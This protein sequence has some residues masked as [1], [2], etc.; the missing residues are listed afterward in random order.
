MND[1]VPVLSLS[2]VDVY[3]NHHLDHLP[4]PVGLRLPGDALHAEGLHHPLPPR[5]ERAQT[6]TQ[7]QG[8]SLASCR[9][10]PALNQ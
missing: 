10:F 9:P 7:L 4:Q 5:A 8:E 3:P 1:S 2:L 6:E